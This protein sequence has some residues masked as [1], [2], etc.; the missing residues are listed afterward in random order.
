MVFR[1]LLVV[2]VSVGS[3]VLF[4]VGAV[5]SEQQQRPKTAPP[6]S[7][8]T[9]PQQHHHHD[10]SGGRAHHV[11][12]LGV[13]AEK[14]GDAPALLDVRLGVGLQG[15][16]HVGEL[17]AVAHEEDLFLLFTTCVCVCVVLC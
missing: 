4:G 14:V 17:H 3:V 8:I 9:A 10:T 16:H 6:N 13:V 11:Q 12:R 15:V 5:G 1:V 7:I 2:V